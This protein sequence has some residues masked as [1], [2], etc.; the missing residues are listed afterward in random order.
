MVEL[1]F[2]PIIKEE[3]YKN[4]LFP[5]I[6]IAGPKRAVLLVAGNSFKTPLVITDESKITISDIR[7]GKYDQR[8]DIDMHP[9]NIRFR[10]EAVSAD[11]VSKFTIILS[12]TAVVTEPDVV[13]QE[14]INDV[15]GQVENLMLSQIE[16]K[17]ADFS[18]R[19]SSLLKRELRELFSD[20]NYLGNGISISSININI[21]VDKKYEDLLKNKLDLKYNAELEQEKAYTAEKMKLIYKDDMT[22]VFSE[23]AMG[24]ISSQ[25]AIQKSKEGLAKDFDERMRQMREVTQFVKELEKDEMIN[26]GDTLKNVNSLINKLFGSIDIMSLEGRNNLQLEMEEEIDYDNIFQPF[27]DDED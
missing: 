8:I 14:H 25:E 9:N 26:K 12:A 19:D 11:N 13:F 17:A 16:D 3:A 15:A 5:I 22:A 23:F 20:V 7:K 10:Q 27:T 2:N 21:Q 4:G 6:P 1:T 18:I 24:K